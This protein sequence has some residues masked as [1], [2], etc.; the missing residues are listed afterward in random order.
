MLINI[1]TPCSRP[2]NLKAIAESINIPRENYRWL[3]VYD[4]DT[5][6]TLEIPSEP[7]DYLCKNSESISGN[8]QRNYAI[9]LIN[10]GYVMFLDD[11]TI[12]HPD[13][14]ESV[15]DCEEDIVSWA[16]L[17]PQGQHR[18]SPGQFWVCGIDS[19]SFMVK[20][21][22]IGDLRWELDRYDADG[23]FAHYVAKQTTSQRRIEKYLS[24][25]NHLRP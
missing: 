24:I 14:W 19:G 13:F 9:D 2:E 18:L 8:A 25:Y 1:V 6:P 16:Q 12:M 22:V 3:V 20:R 21:S 23:I 10:D 5:F 11:D 7:E 17:T 4:S 15:K